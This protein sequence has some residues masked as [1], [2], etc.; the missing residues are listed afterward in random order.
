M[1]G[2]TEYLYQ[3]TP[4]LLRLDQYNNRLHS[5]AD[6]RQLSYYSLRS[7]YR[8]FPFYQELIRDYNM[9][10]HIAGSKRRLYQSLESL[11]RLMQYAA[12]SFVPE[13]TGHADIQESE[14]IVAGSPIEHPAIKIGRGIVLA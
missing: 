6:P 10:W 1:H 9:P 4:P 14:F 2:F 12:R 8:A 3:A 13:I 5:R 7:L 11:R